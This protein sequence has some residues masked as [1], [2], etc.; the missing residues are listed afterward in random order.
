[1]NRQSLASVQHKPLLQT[2]KWLMVLGA[3]S[4]FITGIYCYLT[5][6]PGDLIR[7]WREA[8]YWLQGYDPIQVAR[9]KTPYLIEYGRMLPGDGYP[10]WAYVYALLTASPVLPFPVV[11]TL[12]L[13]F[14]LSAIVTLGY[15]IRSEYKFPKT[16]EQWPML[17]AA[18]LCSSAVAIAL[19]WHQYGILVTVLIW[20]FLYFEE[21]GWPLCAGL[22]LAFAFIKPQTSALFFLL[23]LMRR[24]FKTCLW[25]GLFLVLATGIAA[26]RCHT[27]PWTMLVETFHTGVANWFYLG[28]GDPLKNIIGAQPLLLISIGI[29]TFI[30]LI[31]LNRWKLA[32]TYYLAAVPAVFSTFWMSHRNHDLMIVSLL[33]VPLFS[34][35]LKQ[36]RLNIVI[37][38]ALFA[39]CFPHFAIFYGE[40]YFWPVPILFRVMWL[41]GLI[42][43]LESVN[44]SQV[45]RKI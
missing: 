16:S 17:F 33:I 44:Y 27:S 12:F 14:N 9:T 8:G 11:K 45:K 36:Q 42:Y 39:Y 29:V 5:G 6:P 21:K 18:A 37:A 4:Y 15:F 26:W 30:V 43:L 20:A 3:I 1:M 41:F 35:A 24:S 31:L 19:R 38:M 2:I 22:S 32:P 40:P 25:C 28:I 7:R 13:I 23:P 34:L 10:P